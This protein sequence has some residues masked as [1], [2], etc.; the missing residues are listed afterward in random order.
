L[1]KWKNRNAP[2]SRQ[3]PSV[4]FKDYG[5]SSPC[6]HLTA[7]SRYCWPINSREGSSSAGGWKVIFDLGNW[8]LAL[9]GNGKSSARF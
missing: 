7:G 3:L 9:N 1:L 2:Q 8:V 6:G 5:E 4:D